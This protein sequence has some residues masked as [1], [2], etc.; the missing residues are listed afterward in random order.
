GMEILGQ[1]GQLERGSGWAVLEGTLANMYMS[2]L[3]YGIGGGSNEIQRNLI[4][5]LGLGLPRG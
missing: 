4:A 2:C 1:Y 3:P 5:L